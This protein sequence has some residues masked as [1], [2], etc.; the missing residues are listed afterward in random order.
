VRTLEIAP[1]SEKPLVIRSDS[2]YAISGTV[3]IMRRVWTLI[4][5]FG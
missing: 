1:I 4:K 2:N 5:C 3:F